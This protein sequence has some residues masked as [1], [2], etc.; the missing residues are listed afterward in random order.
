VLLL[1]V[2]PSFRTAI[3]V[4]QQIWPAFINKLRSMA[5]ANMKPS[6]TL[7]CDSNN[8]VQAIDS[9]HVEYNDDC[10]GMY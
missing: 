3:N 8:D 5:A 4:P 1:Q 2:S 6:D 9:E 10:V 7:H